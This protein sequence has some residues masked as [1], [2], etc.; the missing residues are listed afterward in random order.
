MID[1]IVRG[2]IFYLLLEVL[3]ITLLFT[4]FMSSIFWNFPANTTK[5]KTFNQFPTKFLPKWKGEQTIN[6]Y[7]STMENHAM[8]I[9]Y[10]WNVTKHRKQSKWCKIWN[11]CGMPKEDA[12]SSGQLVLSHFGTYMCS[13]IETN[14]SWTCFRTFEFRTSLSTSVLL[15]GSFF[16]VAYNIYFVLLFQT[17]PLRFVVFCPFLVD[18][19]KHRRIAKLKWFFL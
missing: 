7:L 17:L 6:R 10:I 9:M 19:L 3:E 18:S 1:G 15:Q 12:Y 13:N 4:L 11:G 16:L 8:F 2:E 14:L 5:S